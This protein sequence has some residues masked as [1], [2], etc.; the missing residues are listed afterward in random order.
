MTVIIIIATVTAVLL[1]VDFL[2]ASRQKRR[3]AAGQHAG[4]GANGDR[5]LN[6]SLNYDIVAQQATS[7]RNQSSGSGF[8]F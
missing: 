7:M 6:P 1:G 8:F 5:N 4:G 3:L 2:A